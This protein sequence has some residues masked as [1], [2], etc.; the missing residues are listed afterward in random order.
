MYSRIA[1]DFSTSNDAKRVCE[2]CLL[3]KPN[4]CSEI[5]TFAGEFDII[6]S[7]KPTIYLVKDREFKEG[8][9]IAMCK[10]DH[11]KC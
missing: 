9:I 11:A 1:K 3:Q 4:T 7:I 6:T 2:N 8:I 5:G 10:R